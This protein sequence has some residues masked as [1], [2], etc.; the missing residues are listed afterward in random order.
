MPKHYTVVEI[1]LFFF[2]ENLSNGSALVCILLKV[3]IK[4]TVYFFSVIIIP[5]DRILKAIT[6]RGL[7]VSEEAED[8]GLGNVFFM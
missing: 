2:H 4:L 1:F 3:T 7:R 6:G 8:V 5:L